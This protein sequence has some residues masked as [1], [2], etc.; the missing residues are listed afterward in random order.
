MKAASLLS[1][2]LVITVGL[3]ADSACAKDAQPA[4]I[5]FGQR[6]DLGQHLVAGKTVLFDFTSKF[7]PRCEQI[8]PLLHKLH[9]TRD[10]LVVVEVDI[11]RPG[12]NGVDWDS[13]VAIQFGFEY[14]PQF[15]IFGP[16]GELVAQG[17]KARTMVNAWTKGIRE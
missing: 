7:C 17:P 13:P 3:F 6:V 10:D 11:N 5:A 9:E 16:G 15:M 1:A 14:L 8:A 2:L 12:Y 4:R